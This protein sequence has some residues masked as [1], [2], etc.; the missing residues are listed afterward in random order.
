MKYGLHTHFRMCGNRDSA[1]PQFY[2]SYLGASTEDRASKAT[3]MTLT[4]T[5]TLFSSFAAVSG[6][7]EA[8]RITTKVK[9]TEP[10]T[11]VCLVSFG[12]GLKD[13]LAERRTALEAAVKKHGID[14]V[15]A[16][17]E[18]LKQAWCGTQKFL[19]VINPDLGFVRTLAEMPEH[20]Y[21]ECI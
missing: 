9:E 8:S 19:D 4:A 21:G 2:Y 17:L 20:P 16:R 7:E 14:A 5:S 13:S 11:E 1:W 6:A 15:V 18:F 3:H 12:Y 10:T